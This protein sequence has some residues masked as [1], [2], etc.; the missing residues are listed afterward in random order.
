MAWLRRSFLAGFFVTVPLVIS[1]AAL[2]WIFGIIDGFTAPL[3][4]QVLGR[5]CRLASSSRCWSSDSWSRGHECHRSAPA[6]ARGRLADDD[7]V[8]RT[9]TRREAARRGVSRTTK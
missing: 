5:E 8:F 9:V 4:T 6:D 7:P 1:V 3:A 2:V